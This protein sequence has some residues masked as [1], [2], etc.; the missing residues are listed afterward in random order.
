M[1]PCTY[2]LLHLL[3]EAELA[4]AKNATPQLTAVNKLNN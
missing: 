3:K 1:V 2:K 4:S